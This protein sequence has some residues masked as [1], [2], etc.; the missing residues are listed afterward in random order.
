MQHTLV[1]AVRVSYRHLHWGST[2]RSSSRTLAAQVA[3]CQ[4]KLV[5]MHGHMAGQP[6][7]PRTPTMPEQGMLGLADQAD[8]A[9]TR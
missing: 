1:Q 8:I 9:C 3:S 2:L 4:R 5:V 6:I 7:D